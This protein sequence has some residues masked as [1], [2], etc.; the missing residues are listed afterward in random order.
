MDYL[1]VFEGRQRWTGQSKEGS[2]EVPIQYNAATENIGISAPTVDPVYF[3]APGRFP[4]ICL[5]ALT[6]LTVSHDQS[7]TRS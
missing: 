5:G 6:F 4:E 7:D 3:V 1:S 2:I